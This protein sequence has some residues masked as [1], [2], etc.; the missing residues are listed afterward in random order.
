MLAENKN[1]PLIWSVV[2]KEIIQNTNKNCVKKI[3]GCIKLQS[4]VFLQIY[5]I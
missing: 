4:K 2:Y 3:V 1:F 5:Y